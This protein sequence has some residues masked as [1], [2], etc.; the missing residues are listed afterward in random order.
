MQIPSTVAALRLQAPPALIQA[1]PN[2]VSGGIPM[3]RHSTRN[4]DHL[5]AQ[6]EIR[7][8]A[9]RIGGESRDDFP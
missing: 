7:A 9:F 6:K 4:E 1:N 3:A 8:D 5:S 2:R